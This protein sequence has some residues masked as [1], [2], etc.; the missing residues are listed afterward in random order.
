MISHSE[1]PLLIMSVFGSESEKW[2][3]IQ[4]DALKLTTE[5]YEH[6]IYVNN[7]S[8]EWVSLVQQSLNKPNDFRGCTVVGLSNTSLDGKMQHYCGLSKLLSYAHARR[9]D[10]RAWLVLDCDCFPIASNWESIL[11]GRNSSIV[12]VENL[13]T[14]Y[15]PSAVYC[16][17]NSLNFIIGKYKNI[18]GDEFDELMAVGSFFPL[19]RTN[20]LNLHPLKYGIYY[21]IFYHHCAGSRRFET[22][23]DSYYRTIDHETME[24]YDEEFFRDKW[25]FIRK[26]SNVDGF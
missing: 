21:D 22:R 10:Y 23:S 17:D 2:L 11:N 6:A 15:H 13:D 3:D 5:N 18:L 19:L 24:R 25:S 12:R 20:R 9:N 4:I 14:F 26:I 16:V 8:D 7:P 1:K